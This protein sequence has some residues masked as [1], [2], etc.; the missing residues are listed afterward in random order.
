LSKLES[1]AEHYDPFVNIIE[2]RSDTQ[3]WEGS[4]C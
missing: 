3:G 1:I 4:Y 2:N